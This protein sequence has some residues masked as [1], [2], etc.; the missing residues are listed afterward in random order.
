MGVQG[1][2]GFLEE[3]GG[4]LAELRVSDTRLV[5]DGSG[6][7]HCLCLAA[8]TDL[9]RGG[10]YGLLA[11][12]VRDFFAALR[13]C[14]VAAFVV[15]DGGRGAGD[16]K[17]L[18]LRERAAERLRA[19]GALSRGGPGALVPLLARDTFVQALS[20]FGVP[21]VQSYAEADRDGFFRTPALAALLGHLG[22]RRRE[23]VAE[24][25][26][27]AMEAYE[28]SDADLD[29]FFRGGTYEAG[30]AGWPRW[31]RDALARGRLPPFVS[32]ALLLRSVFLRVQ[33]EDLARPSA[34]GAA[35]PLRRALYGLLLG[36]P[37]PGEE[38]PTVCEFDRLR[39]T[40]RKTRVEAATLPPGCQ[41]PLEALAEV[42]LSSRRQ[43]LL[44][45]LGVQMSSLESTPSHLQLPLAVTCHW[46]RASEPRVELH[47]LQALLLT[48]VSGEEQRRTREPDPP[49]PGAEEGEDVACDGFLSWKEKA[50]EGEAFD[51]A[52]AHGLCQWQSCL[53]MG[54]Y[55]NQLLSAP[56]P[57]P[58]LS[59]LFSGTLA[60][61]LCQ[62]LKSAPSLDNLC[63]FS[64]AMTQLYQA[65]LN[66][67]ES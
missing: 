59:S 19:A 23:E 52:V 37:Q 63:G 57:E 11:A 32:D 1:L 8:G 2:S 25:L 56:L 12:A 64:P 41:Y 13:R 26:R 61:R 24:R 62:E 18:V 30:A 27:A 67:V 42:P 20:R 66:T 3:Q 35:L 50:P 22:A 21:F 38:P 14:R 40:L 9:R 5:I 7:Y 65:L 43:L 4:F 48:L 36:P 15:L 49:V 33:V 58:D 47:Q 39:G 46:V 34:H 10:D 45:P 28:P 31:V 53:Q 55:L 17:L 60:H 29:G 6:L 51:L 16:P 44:E 54:L